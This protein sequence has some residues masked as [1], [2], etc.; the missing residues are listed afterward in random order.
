MEFLSRCITLIVD[1]PAI[2]LTFAIAILL[3]YIFYL[4][5]KI[6]AL[7]RGNSGASLEEVI[8]TCLV[9]VTE[10]EK[11]NELIAKHALT[12]EEKVG[13]A[14][15]N[16]QTI[17]YKAFD[18]NGSNQSFSVAL[19]N[20]KGNGVVISSLHSHDRMS[21]FAKPIENYESTYELTEEE[22]EVLGRAKEEHGT[23]L[24]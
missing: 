11:K 4:D 15:R 10:I 12:L 21:T 14:L 13:T 20:E 6:V 22:L 23:I 8:R 18:Q 16:A 17:R 1:N 9:S 7:T 3:M 19:V 2:P 24:G 5:H